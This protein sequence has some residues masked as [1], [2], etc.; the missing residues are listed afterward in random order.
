MI[1]HITVRTKSGTI[2]TGYLPAADRNDLVVKLRAH[3]WQLLEVISESVASTTAPLPDD[4]IDVEHFKGWL[5][6][7][8]TVVLLIVVVMI[9]QLAPSPSASSYAATPSAA[10]RAKLDSY[11][12]VTTRVAHWHSDGV[13]VSSNHATVADVDAEASR[14]Q[15]YARETASRSATYSPV[16]ENGDRPGVDNN[17]DGRTEPVHVTGYH[18]SDGTYVREQYRALPSSG[19]SAS[20][21]PSGSSGYSSGTSGSSSSR[22]SGGA[23][24]VKG[25][26]RKN[27]TY[28]QPHTRSAPRR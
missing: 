27:G 4:G 10:E 7:G 6:G 16:A 9:A 18:R 22:P 23:V 25:Y 2:K 15:A 20:A 11:Q 14:L 28:V 21:L 5:I 8:A 3:G 26:Y 1:Y 24:Q 19:S 13:F 17:G 12:A